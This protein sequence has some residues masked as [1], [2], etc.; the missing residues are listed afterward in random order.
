MTGTN[1]GRYANEP[2]VIRSLKWKLDKFVDEEANGKQFWYKELAC[3]G[4]VAFSN[5]P[6]IYMY[7]TC[8]SL[9]TYLSSSK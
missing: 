3:I 4:L 7:N 6:N 8:V 1:L 2:K 9:C 5:F